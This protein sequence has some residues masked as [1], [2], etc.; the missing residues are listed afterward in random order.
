MYHL[1]VLTFDSSESADGARQSIRDLQNK[2]LLTLEDAAVLTADAS[3]K[4]S[5]NNE[6]GR[7]I[8]IGAG[9]GAVVG[10]LLS[11]MFPLAGILIGAAGGALIGR[12]LDRGVDQKFVQDVKNSLKP[13][14]SALFLVIRQADMTAL[15]ATLAP[16]NA[17]ILQT[18]LE[19]S[20]VD[21]IR[22]SN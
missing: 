20:L 19:D 22:S 13:N 6:L 8:K 14:S 7:D 3:G 1:L 15:R 10:L 18:T 2:G 11:F 21:Q 4:V 12:S 5:V 9:I 17:G 16:H